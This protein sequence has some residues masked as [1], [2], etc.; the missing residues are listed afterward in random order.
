MKN[1]NITA[2]YSGLL[3]YVQNLFGADIVKNALLFDDVKGIDRCLDHAALEENLLKNAEA[4]N[5]KMWYVPRTY[6]HHASLLDLH[7]HYIEVN[8]HGL[9]HDGIDTLIVLGHLD[10][11]DMGHHIASQLNPPAV[12]KYSEERLADDN[13]HS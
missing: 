1:V 13:L 2:H 8:Y 11:K 9:T 7:F 5:N 3:E 4:S 12:T 6:R 10:G